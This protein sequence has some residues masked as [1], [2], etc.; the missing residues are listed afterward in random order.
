MYLMIFDINSKYLVNIWSKSINI[1]QAALQLFWLGAALQLLCGMGGWELTEVRAC[2][3]ELVSTCV[4]AYLDACMQV[5]TYVFMHA[6][7]HT[8]IYVCMHLLL[9]VH[10][11]MCVRM[12]ECMSACMVHVLCESIGVAV[13][14]TN[15]EQ[16]CSLHHLIWVL[17]SEPGFF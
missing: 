7:I 12:S 4:S 8:G 10:A 3:H 14:Y 5:F 17:V 15:T 11:R 6:R 2:V 13:Q 1:N 16:I 9:C